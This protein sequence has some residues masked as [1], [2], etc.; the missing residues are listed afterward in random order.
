MVCPYLGSF[1]RIALLKCSSRSMDSQPISQT[2][3]RGKGKAI[4]NRRTW[5]TNEEHCLVTALTEICCGGW[6]CD[7]DFKPG[8]LG[9]LEK[10]MQNQ[11]PSTDLKWDPHILS[12]IH[13]W[14]KHY[15]CFALCFHVQVL[16]GT[17]VQ[18]LLM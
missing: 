15:G 12:K 18:T 2:S 13:V 11:F 6:K 3:N 8:Y 9:Q 10:A 17:T 4:S 7:N 14:R 1:I 16:D 5:R